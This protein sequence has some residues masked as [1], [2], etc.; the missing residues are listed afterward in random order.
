[1]PLSRLPRLRLRLRL[2]SSVLPFTVRRLRYS[3]LCPPAQLPSNGRN[4][5]GL[6]WSTPRPL[7]TTISSND[8]STLAQMAVRD[9]RD[10]VA[11]LYSTPLP[12]AATWM[13][14]LPCS[15]RAL[16]RTSIRS[17]PPHG[18]QRC[19]R[20]SKAGTRLR[21]GSSLWPEQISITRILPTSVPRLSPLSEGDTRPL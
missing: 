10:A 15:K 16:V 5:S 18:G 11:G 2:Q 7:A 12:S 13:W 3:S 6:R 8:W 19:T 14:S 9:G 4:G 17:R 20:Q 21:Q 1:M